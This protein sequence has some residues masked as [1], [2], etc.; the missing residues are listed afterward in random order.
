MLSFFTQATLALLL[1]RPAL[2]QN[3]PSS[4]RFA[5]EVPQSE[6]VA[7]SNIVED[8]PA[9]LPAARKGGDESPAYTL[10]SAALPIPPVAQVKQK[11]INPVTNKEIWYYELDIKPFTHQIYPGKKAA[12]LV[13]YNGT[14]PGPTI[15]VPR[16]TETVVRF[17]NHGDRESSI[18]L[19]G[20]P[21][22]APFDGWAEDLIMPGQY[23]DYYYPNGQSAR[24]LWYHDHAVHFTAENAYF[25]QAGAYLV[26]DPA[27]NAL[28]L[29]SGYGQFDIPLVLAS[30]YYNSD[31][32]LKSSL[33][34]EESLWGDVVHVNGVPWP[35]MNVQPRKYRFRILNA[36]VSRNFDLYFVKS[37]ATNT[38]LPFKVIASDAGLLQNAV[39]VQHVITAVAERWEIVMDFSAYAGQTILLR[40]NQDAGGIGTDDEYDN[41]DKVMQ[42]KVSA[43]PV[44]DTSTVPQNLRT[45]PFPPASTGID[46]EFRFHRSNSQWQINDVGFADAANRVLAKVP[47]GKVEIWKLENKSG[48][49]T[50]PVHV[51]L[52]DFRIL[53]RSGRGVEPYEAAGLKDVVWLGKNEEVLVEAHYAPWN[54]VYMFHCHNL[55]HEDH[56]MMAAFNVTQLQELGY[57]EQTDFSDPEDPRWSAVPFVQADWTSRSG[58]FTSQA[59]AA[60]IREIAQQQPYSEQAQVE[61]A[62]AAA[63]ADGSAQKRSVGEECGGQSSGPISRV[64]RFVV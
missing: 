29:P 9:N 22:R 61:A 38:K 44:T 59:V 40:N 57:N 14:S 30:K 45:V 58:P 2:A 63:W 49:W 8:D 15:I 23:K 7:L 27:D 18:H 37:T 3:N 62:L 54:G 46:H 39:Q 13:G 11:V 55:I 4:N 1:S 41:T 26:T 25:G 19:H 48:G 60:R 42:F 10:Y 50:H 33:G 17:V 5:S 56:D 20:S 34:E 53:Q 21:S 24:F 51:H 6:T 35:S 31:G 32:T 43:T 36:A 12:R 64:R 16:G 47:R 28:G 52:V